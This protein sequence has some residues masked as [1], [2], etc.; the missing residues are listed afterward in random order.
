MHLKNSLI[1]I[2][3]IGQTLV[4]SNKLIVAILILTT[5]QD[6]CLIESILSIT[7]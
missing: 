3:E 6:K 5:L 2:L 1:K 7:F 4:K